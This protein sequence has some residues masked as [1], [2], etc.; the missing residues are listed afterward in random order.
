ML[1]IGKR[2]WRERHMGE[3]KHYAERVVK[4]AVE[5]RKLVY[6][7]P[8]AMHYAERAKREADSTCAGPFG[9]NSNA[10]EEA[11]EK[12]KEAAERAHEAVKSVTRLVKVA[13]RSMND[14]GAVGK[15]W[16]E[17]MEA[18]VAKSFVSSMV[19]EPRTDK[20]HDELKKEQADRVEKIDEVTSKIREKLGPSKE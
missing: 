15:E 9:P 6:Q 17:I 8:E 16:A 3:A 7:A 10:E 14:I 13:E 1:E 4:R 19:G 12:A 5:Y 18:Y 2:E 11:F 20:D